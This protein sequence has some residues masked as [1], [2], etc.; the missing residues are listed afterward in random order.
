MSILEVKHLTKTYP[1]F[2]LSDISFSLEEGKITGFIGRNGAGK[3]T[4][5]KSV[6]GFVH[7]D[8]GEIK[9]FDMDFRDNEWQI[10]QDLGYVSGGFTFYPIKKLKTITKVTREFYPNWDEALYKKYCEKFHLDESKTPAKLSEGM[11]VKYSIALALSHH[12]KLL[13]LDEP[14]SGLD[15][16]SRDELL[17]IFMELQEKGTT[18]FFSTHITSDL[19]KCADNIIYIRNGRLAHASSLSEF[20]NAYKLV[21]LTEEEA[22][23]EK[24]SSKG[25][26]SL[27]LGCKKSKEGY[28]AIVKTE[29]AEKVPGKVSDADLETI[30]IHLEKE[31]E[32]WEN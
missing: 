23:R 5:L 30:M 7:P 29:N 9:F 24:A 22:E 31:G 15:P 6:L 20:C 2:K 21:E 11:K 27:L 17:D 13:I 4:T 14:T 26:G 19:D 25:E 16:I 28:T 1:A 12:A 10:K 18:I 3:T 32:S 8:S